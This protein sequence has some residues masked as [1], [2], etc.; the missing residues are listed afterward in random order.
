MLCYPDIILKIN[1]CISI[2][3]KSLC[4]EH[5]SICTSATEILLFCLH[6]NSVSNILLVSKAG[7]V[8]IE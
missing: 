4:S 3:S 1:K 6:E 5:G 8:Y 7:R 2:F